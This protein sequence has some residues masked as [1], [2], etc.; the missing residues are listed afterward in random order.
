MTQVSNY[1]QMDEQNVV[2]T[3]KVILLSLKKEGSS[4]TCQTD[5][6]WGHYGIWSHM[7]T[8]D[9]YSRILLS[10]VYVA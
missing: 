3:P 5:E 7:L 10:K 6:P 9:K 2:Y 8:K 4:D 1:N